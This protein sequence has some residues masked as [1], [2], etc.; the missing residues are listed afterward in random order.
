MW[1]QKLERHGGH[2]AIISSEG[3]YIL[4]NDRLVPERDEH[5]SNDKDKF[6]L[7]G[8]LKTDRLQTISKKPVRPQ[9]QLNES[10]LTILRNDGSVIN[11]V[12]VPLYAIQVMTISSDDGQYVAVA[13][14]NK[15]IFLETATGNVLW[16]YEVGEKGHWIEP[17]AVSTGGQLIAIGVVNV[18]GIE[19]ENPRFELL[20]CDGQK[21]G[22]M[23][24]EMRP[25]IVFT[26]DSRYLVSHFSYNGGTQTKIYKVMCIKCT[27]IYWIVTRILFIFTS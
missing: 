15:L 1:S 20:N 16:I 25:P 27:T 7:D 13:G 17:V 24:S 10:Y 6:Q 4:I 12:S 8:E 2:K 21:I 18:T 11:E 19:P 22:Q 14:G 9:F 3:S 26:G 5:D 23:S